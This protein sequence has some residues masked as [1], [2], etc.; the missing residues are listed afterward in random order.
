MIKTKSQIIYGIEITSA[1]RYIDWKEGATSYSAE[2][3]PGRYVLTT[4]ARKLQETLNSK[5]LLTY[6]C[7]IDRAQR[8]IT[9]NA[10]GSFELLV[11]NPPHSGNVAAMLGFTANK[12]GTSAI[13]DIGLGT[14]YT[15]PRYL[16]DYTSP[17]DNCSA[18]SESVN[19]SAN[20]TVEVF[21]LGEKRLC[22]FNIDYI[23]DNAG[24]Y[25]FLENEPGMK[26][27]TRDLLAYLAKKGPVDFIPDKTKP[28]EF[29]TLIMDKNAFNSKGTGFRLSE[30][31][32]LGHIDIW[33]TKL[34]TFRVVDV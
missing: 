2:L 34:I 11:V 8:K 12:T 24:A 20:G 7:S 33:E 10:S 9:I 3:P 29:Y 13:S 17:D 25:D 18:I 30:M 1:N 32:G 14:V 23:T 27:K 16:Q 28:E 19:E 21:S 4:I 5:G 22:E 15:P 31:N 6:T 26:Q